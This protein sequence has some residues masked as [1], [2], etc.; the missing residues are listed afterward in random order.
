MVNKNKKTEVS[1][2]PLFSIS[3]ITI[4]ILLLTSSINSNAQNISKYYTST[5][6]GNSMLY[7]IFPQTGFK[8][9]ELK[10]TF[11]Y[12]ITYL[13]AN[14]S[15]FL[16]FSYFDKLNRTIDSVA[17]IS[18]NH[19]FSSG[20]KKLFI[21]TQGQKWHY[22][23][24]SKILFTDLNVFFNQADKPKIIIYTHEGS[25]ELNINANNWKRQSA[26]TNK[27]ITLIKYNH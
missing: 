24:S 19:R 20:V 10:S 4:F 14:D 25:V 12:D 26:I 6:Q 2:A 16:N 8:N 23:Y 27:I 13:T 22:R 3:V 7:F 1:K 21:E 17:F 9:N 5:I 15:A 18:A 11:K